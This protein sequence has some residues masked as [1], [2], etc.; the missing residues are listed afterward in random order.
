MKDEVRRIIIDIIKNGSGRDVADMGDDAP[1]TGS[2]I[3][4]TAEDMIYILMK[5]METYHVRFECEDFE[6]YRFNTVNGI[7]SALQKRCGQT[8]TDH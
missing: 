6:Y 4:A 5:I 8:I 2:G 3:G 1:L 7:V